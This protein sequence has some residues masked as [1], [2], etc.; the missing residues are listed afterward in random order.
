MLFLLSFYTTH[1]EPFKTKFIHNDKC[2]VPAAAYRMSTPTNNTYIMI[3]AG[4][5]Y[6]KQP[7]NVVDVFGF[8]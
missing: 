7:S 4:L 1:D 8:W 2:K 5:H 6:Q 3:F